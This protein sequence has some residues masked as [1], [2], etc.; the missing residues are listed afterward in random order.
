[1]NIDMD[2]PGELG[3]K[4]TYLSIEIDGKLVR[5]QSLTAGRIKV[6]I[7]LSASIDHTVTLSSDNPLVLPNG[8]GRSVIGYL[9]S[10]SME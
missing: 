3:Q 8:D 7:D 10:I 4:K 6:M 5:R 2:I 9:R 1:M